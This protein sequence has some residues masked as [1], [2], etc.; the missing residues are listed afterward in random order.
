MEIIRQQMER[1]RRENPTT[2]QK[3]VRLDG[4][5][6]KD[7]TGL[8]SCFPPLT[9][10]GTGG[11]SLAMVATDSEAAVHAANGSISGQGGTVPPYTQW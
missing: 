5:N 7:C 4:L 2:W 11:N 8:L 3:N 9:D 6:K 1:E 10:A